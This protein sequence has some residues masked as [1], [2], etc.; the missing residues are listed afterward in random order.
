MFQEHVIAGLEADTSFHDVLDTGSLLEQG[1]NNGGSSG[2]KRSFQ[3]VAEY[4]Q[5]RVESSRLRLGV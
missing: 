5:D 2:N 1:V 4:G 3:Q